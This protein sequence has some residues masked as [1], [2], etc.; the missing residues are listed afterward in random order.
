M[1]AQGRLRAI[2]LPLEVALPTREPIG[3]VYQ[4]ADR[5]HTPEVS[6][7][8]DFGSYG[9]RTNLISKVKVVEQ[10]YAWAD[11]SLKI[12]AYNVCLGVSS[13]TAR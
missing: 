4:E 5:I 9:E 7:N 11:I 1:P 12:R 10:Q 8:P 13:K 3:M 6:F 2:K